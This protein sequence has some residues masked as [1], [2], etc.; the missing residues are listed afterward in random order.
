MYEIADRAWAWQ[1]LE[2]E[3]KDRIQTDFRLMKEI[4][5]QGG[6]ASEIAN[7]LK[8]S[9]APADIHWIPWIRQMASADLW[10]LTLRAS[11]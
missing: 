1:A 11:M 9:M 7:I 4:Q 2:E 3:Y 6:R 8:K 5:G 10:T